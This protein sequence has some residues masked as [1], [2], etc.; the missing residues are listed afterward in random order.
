ME[1]QKRIARFTFLL[2]F[3]I[4]IIAAIDFRSVSY[5]GWRHLYFIYPSFLL[6]AMFAV[7]LIKIIFFKKKNY[8]LYI[9]ILILILPTG[10]WMYKNHPFQY[11]YFNFLA[12]KNFNEKFE[13]DYL[14]VSNKSALEYIIS[15]DSKKIKVYNLN[16]TDLY[17][18]KKI[19]RKK[20]RSKIIIVDDIN[21][22]DY[23]TNNFTDWRG[24]IKP[25]N[26]IKPE[27]FNIIHEI[28]VDDITINTIYKKKQ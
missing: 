1:R 10:I 23:I 3:L 22:A 27:N 13:M 6:I 21:N 14:G 8:F 4:P 24:E 5:D 26:F 28:K 25:T 12:G 9:L 15:K 17:V 16:T 19:L 18:S 7:H 2:T 20:D 11:V